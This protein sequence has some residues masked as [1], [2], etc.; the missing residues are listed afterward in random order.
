MGFVVAGLVLVGLLGLLNLL[1]VAGV[2]RRL[3]QHTELLSGG[4]APVELPTTDPTVSV[5]SRPGSFS[6]MAV[7]GEPV[8]IPGPTIV[9]FFAPDCSSC[10][11][12][13]SDF[14]LGVVDLGY[15]RA[16]V[17][18]VAI[19]EPP[20]TDRLSTTLGRAARVV[21]EPMD[22]PV[23]TA[24]AVHGVPAMCRLDETGTVVATGRDL[25]E[26]SAPAT[27]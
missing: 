26:I 7:D 1:L 18:A 12:K 22:G 16:N 21:V 2:I 13:V 11:A 8:S 6:V 20:A 19:G 5:G 10:V 25:T 14:V 24:F 17:L 15:D 3:R 9:G 27:V 4:A 23:A